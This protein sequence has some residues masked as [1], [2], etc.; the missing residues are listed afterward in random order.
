MNR[1]WR[2]SPAA[3]PPN[4]LPIN[5][6]ILGTAFWF[7]GEEVH[8]PVDVRKDETDRI[9]N[10][11]D[12]MSKTFLGLTVA[13]ARCH[14]HKFDAISQRD[15]YALAGFAISGSYR[16]IRVDTFE[17]DR[18]IARQLEKLR[19]RIR[20]E[21]ALA[22]HRA[23]RPVM[24]RLD[25][26]WLIARSA[27]DDDPLNSQLVASGQPLTERTQ[28]LV[29]ELAHD[30]SLDPK[31]LASWCAELSRA[32]SDEQHPLHELFPMASARQITGNT[33]VPASAKVVQAPSGIV[34]NFGDTD[35][36][37]PIQNGVS[38]GL[39]PTVPGHLMIEGTPNRLSWKSRRSER[40]RG[41]YSGRTF[42]LCR[43]R[44]PT[45]AP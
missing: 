3:N 7:L 22:L 33:D 8:S 30:N 10:R 17:Q 44:R 32:K 21:V 11:L 31:K 13:C 20:H 41:T 34:V 38:F 45:M 23:S 5:E 25:Q 36:N 2:T 18:Q 9:D 29:E 24:N 16:Q 42:R 1:A 12:V 6:S 35:N 28:K 4:A 26:Y 37:L 19:S 39:S 43:G 40:G 14:D 15:Y 27:L